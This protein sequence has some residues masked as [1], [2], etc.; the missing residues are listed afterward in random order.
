MSKNMLFAGFGG[1][2]IQF[3]AKV[4]AYAGLVSGNNVSWLP[5][6][7]PEMRGGTSNCAVCIDK[8]PIA[9]PLVT[10]PEILMVLNEP[11]YDKFINAVPENGTVVIDSFLVK[12]KSDRK[13]INL[14]YIP[15]TQLANEKHFN[16]LANMIALGYML[17][18]V[19]IIEL[20]WI[21]KGIEKCVPASKKDMIEKNIEAIK[22]GYEFTA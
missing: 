3:V 17:K 22:I 4:M 20:E 9:S 16:G 5:S 14:C 11:S 2:G 15:A 1:Q 12:T 18:N 8:D 6:Y 7:G 13:D 21:Y 10:E 19:D